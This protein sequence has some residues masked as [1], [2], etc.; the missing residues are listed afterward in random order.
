MRSLRLALGPLHLKLAQRFR[1]EGFEVG[2][3]TDGIVVAGGRDG[4]R[5]L[6]VREHWCPPS[7]TSRCMHS[8]IQC[9]DPAA[10]ARSRDALYALACQHTVQDLFH[11]ALESTE[12]YRIVI[13]EPSV[14]HY[15]GVT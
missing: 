6:G 9:P 12:K 13:E 2:G 5:F 4:A 8:P 15:I 14:V 11:Y 7:I 1:A 3:E 10:V